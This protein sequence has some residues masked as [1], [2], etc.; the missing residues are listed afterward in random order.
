MKVL[1]IT[2]NPHYTLTTKG[3][4]QLDVDRCLKGKGFLLTTPLIYARTGMFTSVQAPIF[5]ITA[6]V[7]RFETTR[8]LLK[9]S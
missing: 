7:V 4:P 3:M 1:Q 6:A 8:E 9:P 5:T 2:P